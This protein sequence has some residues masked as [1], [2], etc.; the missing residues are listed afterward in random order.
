[1]KKNRWLLLFAM[2]LTL[3]LFLAACNSEESSGNE[4]EGKDEETT[5]EGTEGEGEEATDGEA[6]QGGT[7]TFG[8]DAT[9]EGL[10]DY[11]FYGIQT[12]DQILQFIQENLIEFDEEL[13][14]IPNIA[15]WTTE[16]NK[17]F[18]FT[19]EE[20]VKWHTGE[21][22]TVNDWV[23]ALETIAHPD[24]D[25]PRY[26][27]VKTIEGAEAF[28]NGE[29]DTISGL[30]VVSDYEIKV[31]FDKA[32]VN[33]LVNLWTYPMNKAQFE[34][35]EVADM[36][37]SEMVRQTPVG[38]GPFKVE[39]IVPGESYKL[40]AFEDYRL[41][42]PNLDQVIIK[43]LD[44]TAVTGALQ[45]DEIDVLGSVHP[46]VG[47]DV[48]AMEN[49]SLET[50]P[51]LSY[52][53]VGFKLGKFDNEQ[54]KVVEQKDKYGDKQ[55]RQAM[56]YAID[57]EAWIEAFFQGYGTPV[58]RPVP[59]SHWI[60]ADNADL[61]TYEY[62]PEKAMSLLDEAGYVDVD[63]D[64]FREDPNG[65]DF[66][67]D[68]SHYATSNPT[69]ESRAKALTQYW[70][71]IGL[72]TS[73]EMV[74][75]NLYY[76][77]LESDAEEIETFFGGWG[78]GA[79]PDPSG[80]WKSDVLWNYPRWVSEESD[81]LLDDALDIEIVGDDK[82]KRKE[83]Y[84]EWQQLVNEE[85]PMIFI[86]ELQELSGVNNRVGGISF[87]VTGHNNPMEWYIKE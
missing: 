53:Y 15:D 21:E 81:K 83:L 43:V 69:F 25:G 54:Q 74:E 22:L 66:V 67:V 6:P 36:S 29:A 65:E 45:N 79:D 78:Y 73:L 3:S 41:G 63:D 76:D 87:D 85:L 18:T 35:I 1:M 7:L 51:G 72:E 17:V 60:A 8:L 14:P 2:L 20:G 5:E 11:A 33:N 46:T 40:T 84:V 75:V 55:L 52:Y 10:L 61:N 4:E 48:E 37:G 80:L 50:Y 58:N 59:T 32:R 62:D 77:M 38:T 49:V 12:D 42:K 23:F 16:D 64:G 39:E 57:R 47:K 24:Y 71:D 30:E 82:E 86:A 28:H 31:T 68:F 26:T 44:S 9:P 34:G 19:F 70:N 56:A 13:N 27:N